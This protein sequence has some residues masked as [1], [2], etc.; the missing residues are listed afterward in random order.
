MNAD[1][2]QLAKLLDGGPFQHQGS[3]RLYGYAADA[4]RSAGFQRL[5]ANNRHVE[6]EILLRL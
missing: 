3:P 2:V 5:S 6:P 1:F 4:G